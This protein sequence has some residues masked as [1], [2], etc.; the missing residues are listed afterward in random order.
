M[1]KAPNTL[2]GDELYRDICERN[3]LMTE[4]VMWW[5]SLSPTRQLTASQLAFS[6]TMG[7]LPVEEVKEW[8]RQFKEVIEKSYDDPFVNLGMRE[9][10][11]GIIEYQYKPIK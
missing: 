1:S 7:Q 2:K 4:F 8:V 6:M 11:D 9:S 3:A 5:R 10:K